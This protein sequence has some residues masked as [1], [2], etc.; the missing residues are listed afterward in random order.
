M[1]ADCFMQPSPAP[2]FCHWECGRSVH[3]H[4]DPLLFG[5]YI[6]VWCNRLCRRQLSVC[7]V[8][9]LEIVLTTGVCVLCSE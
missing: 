2:S 1:E 8:Y 5:R 9:V 6:H 3:P 7:A 4:L